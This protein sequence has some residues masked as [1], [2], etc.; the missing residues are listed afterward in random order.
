MGGMPDTG[1]NRRG[2]RAVP[3]KPGQV[4]GVAAMA[5][6]LCCSQSETEFTGAAGL[7]GP[8]LGVLILLTADLVLRL[9]NSPFHW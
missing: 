3:G 9:E 8:G 1:A 5:G 7:L 6:A 4:S 2:E